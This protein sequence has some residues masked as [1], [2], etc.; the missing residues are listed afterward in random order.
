V[1]NFP[2]I[3]GRSELLEFVDQSIKVPAKI[4]TGAY[5]SALHFKSAEEVDRDGKRVL[6]VELLGH[7]SF[8][9]TFLLELPEYELVSVKNSFGVR[10]VRYKIRLKVKLGSKVFWSSF[11]LADRSNNLMPVLIGRELLY[12]R[13]VVDVS[14]TS[15]SRKQLREVY[16]ANRQTELGSKD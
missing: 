12:D 14:K 3:I 9:G 15:I 1:A 4:D 6:K 11:T 13:F 7:P 10:E 8:P 16:N 5:R 2:S